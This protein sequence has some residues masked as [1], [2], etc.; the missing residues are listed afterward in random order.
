MCSGELAEI[1]FEPLAV[2]MVITKKLGKE[3]RREKKKN[4]EEKRR[5]R[6]VYHT[7]NTSTDSSLPEPLGSQRRPKPAR[8][9]TCWQ[10]REKCHGR[11]LSAL[12]SCHTVC[13]CS[14]HTANPDSRKS[15]V[16]GAAQRRGRKDKHH[17][18]KQMRMKTVEEEVERSLCLHQVLHQG[19]QRKHAA[20]L[21]YHAV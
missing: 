17:E 3:K 14:N 21:V 12:C 11:K 7:V 10:H 4:T 19:L 6:K 18:T 15:Q 9:M 8:S 16:R 13:T 2:R 1:N 20:A 5:K